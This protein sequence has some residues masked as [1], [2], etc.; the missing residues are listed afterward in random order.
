VWSF[1][2]SC[3]LS[4]KP[5]ITTTAGG[6]VSEFGLPVPDRAFSPAG[7]CTHNSTWPIK[8]YAD[9][10]GDVYV[11]AIRTEGGCLVALKF[12]VSGYLEDDL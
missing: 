3:A 4:L 10:G 1:T 11:N 2:T 5:S 12:S 6:H 9:P 8:L 7:Y